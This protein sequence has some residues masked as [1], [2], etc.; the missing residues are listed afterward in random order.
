MTSEAAQI[1]NFCESGD[2]AT[3]LPIM[4]MSPND[5]AQITA[6]ALIAEYGHLKNPI[7]TVQEAINC[8]ERTAENYLAGKCAPNAVYL[9]RLLASVP[10]FAAE[11]R[12]LTAM[13]ADLDPR[14]QRDFMRA[15]QAFQRIT[16]R[17]TG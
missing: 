8:N 14:F 12:R 15:V 2:L 7:G 17:A 3:R 11:V 4:S 5:L 1:L 13:E 16:E 10:A 6:R 9:L